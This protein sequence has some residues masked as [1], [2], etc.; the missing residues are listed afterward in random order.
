MAFGVFLLW[1][2]CGIGFFLGQNRDLAGKEKQGRTKHVIYTGSSCATAVASDFTGAI[3]STKCRSFEAKADDF[4][5]RLSS[6]FLG[7]Q[8]YDWK[9]TEWG[10]T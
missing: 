7:E 10:I 5:D 1:I 3:I 9:R 6:S 4:N 8:L 2:L